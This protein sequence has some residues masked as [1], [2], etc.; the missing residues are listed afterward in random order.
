MTYVDQHT[1]DLSATPDEAWAVVC[2]LG[3]DP[4]L[5]TPGPLWQARGLLERQMGARFHLFAFTNKNI[6]N[7]VMKIFDQTFMITYAL[8]LVALVVAVL[9]IVNTMSALILERRHEIA[10]LKVL[11][12]TRGEISLMVV[13]ESAII[14]AT[15]TVL[16]SL[17]GYV[18]ALI[19][20]FVINKQSFGWTIQFDPPALLVAASLAITFLATCLAGLIP[21]R[22]ANRVVISTELK[23]E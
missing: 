1:A 23:S 14:A 15:S 8:L 6:R 20:I 19:L 2:R 12:V 5:W 11:G 22:L 13:L 9:G 21:T 4:E 10:L 17:S 3:G 16:G 18:L 7:E